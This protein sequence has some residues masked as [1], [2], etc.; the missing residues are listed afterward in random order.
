MEEIEAELRDFFNNMY[1]KNIM[2][3]RIPIITKRFRPLFIVI[4]KIRN[5]LAITPLMARML[6]R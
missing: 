4:H 6:S 5:I 3:K 1:P 2:K